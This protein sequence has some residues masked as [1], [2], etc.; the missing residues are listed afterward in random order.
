MIDIICNDIQKAV[1]AGAYISALSLSLA[2]PDW[3]GKAEYPN[4]STRSRYKKWY[5]ENV[6]KYE[7]YEG[8]TGSYLSADVV[9]SLRNHLFHQGALSYDNSDV[10]QEQNKVEKFTLYF[11]KNECDGGSSIIH[12]CGGTKKNV[13]RVFEVNALNL[14]MKLRLCAMGY[15][16]DNKEKFGFLN[17]A[18]LEK[19]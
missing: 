11:N 7:I 4:E 5:S 2:L 14:I 10:H 12:C 8:Y 9:Y 15:F 17:I 18:I 6:G 19:G 1:A 13:S 16:K 3:C